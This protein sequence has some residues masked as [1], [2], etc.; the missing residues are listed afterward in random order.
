MV[1]VVI[2]IALVAIIFLLMA[3]VCACAIIAGRDKEIEQSFYWRIQMAKTEFRKKLEQYSK[4]YVSMCD[5]HKE[6][7]GCPYKDADCC[8]IRFLFDKEGAE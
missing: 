1:K 2:M 6:C 3:L 8:F 5:A 7:S 4:E